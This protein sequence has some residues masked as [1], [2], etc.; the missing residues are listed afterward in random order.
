MVGNTSM[1]AVRTSIKLD[2]EDMWLLDAFVWH[3]NSNGYV[4]TSFVYGKH[5]CYLHH[6]VMGI[7][8]WEGDSIDHI[9]RDKLDNRRSNLRYATKHEQGANTTQTH[10]T[11]N[12]TMRGNRF[13]ID[14]R[15]NGMRHFES[16]ATMEEAIASRNRFLASLT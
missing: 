12:I 8:I 13:C 7:P 15:R 14:I 1:E 4:R 16:C 2:E 9:N 10:N 6:A 3:V 5:K 11:D